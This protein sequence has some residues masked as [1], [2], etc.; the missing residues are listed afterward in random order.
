MGFVA[1]CAGRPL[2]TAKSAV[3]YEEDDR[4]AKRARAVG[5]RP[6]CSGDRERYCWLVDNRDRFLDSSESVKNLYPLF[7]THRD[8]TDRSPDLFP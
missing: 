2:P 1:N 7:G 5:K 6:G 4:L 3:G 8:K